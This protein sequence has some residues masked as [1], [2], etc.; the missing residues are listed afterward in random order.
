MCKLKI[1]G[2]TQAEDVAFANAVRPDYVGF[3]F[4]HSKR[5]VTPESAAL[6][7]SKLDKRVKPVGV[8]VCAHPEFVA[9][10]F[11]SGIIAL[12]QLHGGENEAY[13]CRLRQLS[14][15]PVILTVTAAEF[16]RA[17]RRFAALEAAD[18]WLL[19]AGAGNGATFDWTALGSLFKTIYNA[20]VTPKPWFLA[21][22]IRAEN[23]RAAAALHP[24]AL[25]VSSG[26][27]KNGKKDLEKM[28]LLASALRT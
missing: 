17:E 5:Q 15:V 7:A 11:A 23:I 28:R 10:L 19:D 21:G 3:V 27:E 16:P 9:Q 2:L 6:L 14:S 13:M 20:G 8:F 25:D 12:A 26:A 1:C 22:G 24:F 4:A 18:Y